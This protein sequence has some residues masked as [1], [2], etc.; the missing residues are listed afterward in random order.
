MNF[1][2]NNSTQEEVERYLQDMARQ[3]IRADSRWK[4][5]V[6]GMNLEKGFLGVRLEENFLLPNGIR[7]SIVIDK[8]AIMEQL[9]QEPVIWR[10]K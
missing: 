5:E 7:R 3:R 6:T 2:G 8:T 1:Y 4:V 9:E 10:Y